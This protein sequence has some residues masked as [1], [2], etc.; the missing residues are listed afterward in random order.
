MQCYM[1][2]F[3]R[4]EGWVE[5]GEEAAPATV[6]YGEFENYGGGAGTDGRV[7]WEGYRRMGKKEAERFTVGEFIGG[8]EWIWNHSVPYR[9]G[10]LDSDSI[11]RE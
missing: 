9:S 10:L 11:G 8:D 1:D 4:P 5:W 7:K 3:V 2:G 6:Y